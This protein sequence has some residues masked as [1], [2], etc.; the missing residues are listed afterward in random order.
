[1]ANK[2]SLNSHKAKTQKASKKV[3]LKTIQSE[4]SVESDN[5]SE[6]G[7]LPLRDLKKNLGCGV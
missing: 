1:M 2:P 4:A 3:N 6:Y 5:R 7:G